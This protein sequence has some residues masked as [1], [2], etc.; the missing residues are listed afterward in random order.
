[1]PD[2]P[3]D[4]PS[5]E[6]GVIDTKGIDH[7][8]LRPD[9]RARLEDGRTLMVL[10]SS[11]NDAPDRS[12][13]EFLKSARE[14]G[15]ERALRE[16]V[17]LM[18]LPRSGE[19]MSVKDDSGVRAESDQ[20]GY[21]LKRDHVEAALRAIGM[22]ELPVL[23]FNSY[24]DEPRHLRETL[25]DRIRQVRLTHANRIESVL[26]SVRRL[27]GDIDNE[28]RSAA[29]REAS[30]RLRL[31]LQS[32]DQLLP[33]TKPTHEEP[34]GTVGVTHART[35]WARPVGKGRGR[36]WTCTTISVS[37]RPATHKRGPRKPCKICTRCSTTC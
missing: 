7:T 12:T 3:I 22:P 6:L 5:F 33:R 9:L 11:F 1:L 14:T 24:G 37:Q 21:D 2:S 25:L 27:A 36:T 19:A 10:C 20:I 26:Q 4:D 17:V 15:L 8:S 31:F 30:K 13:Q 23:F 32:A 29:Q 16:R 35:I 28:S 18:V 34:L